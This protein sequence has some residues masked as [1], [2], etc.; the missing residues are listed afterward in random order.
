MNTLEQ[1]IEEVATILGHNVFHRLMGGDNDGRI[2][3]SKEAVVIALVYE[4]DDDYV[5]LALEKAALAT[6]D[7]L[8]AL[9]AEN[10]REHAQG[11][12]AKAKMVA[13]IQTR[14]DKAAV[15][16]AREALATFGG[17]MTEA[18]KD[19]I[20]KIAQRGDFCR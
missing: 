9:Q 16:A 19:G 18:A 8:F 20:R 1:T 7:R 3:A 17:T 4:T 15:Q 14:A 10:I 12:E 13:T 2:D 11:N 6:K 5:E